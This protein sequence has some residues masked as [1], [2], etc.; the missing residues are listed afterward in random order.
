MGGAFFTLFLTCPLAGMCAL[1]GAGSVLDVSA[2]AAARFAEVERA[3]VTEVI[4]VAAGAAAASS[5]E[6]KGAGV[7]RADADDDKR[8][9]P[10]WSRMLPDPYLQLFIARFILCRAALA[11]HRLTAAAAAARLNT[12]TTTAAAAAERAARGGAVVGKTTVG[13]GGGGGTSGDGGN[14]G[15]VGRGSSRTGTGA[16][17]SVASGSGTARDRDG[18]RDGDGDGDVVVD[19]V[20][21]HPAAGGGVVGVGAES[22]VFL[23]T[24]S[25]PLPSSLGPAACAR[26]ILAMAEAIGFEREFHDTVHIQ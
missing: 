12:H 14:F 8:L 3:A 23:P 24:C 15:D 5:P 10:A 21:T 7:A 20:V 18:G 19:R 22:S 11:L 2:E 26:H 25:P 9:D 17:G 6:P 13:S 4:T 1:C 16:G